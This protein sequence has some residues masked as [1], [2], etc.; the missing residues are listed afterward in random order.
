MRHSQVEHSEDSPLFPSE[1]IANLTKYRVPASHVKDSRLDGKERVLAQ[2][3][4]HPKYAVEPRAGKR[5]LASLANLSQ[6]LVPIH[7]PPPPPHPHPP[8]PLPLPVRPRGVRK[9]VIGSK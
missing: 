6:Q 4:C 1:Y 2:S 3:K 5:I 8:P 7:P 9:N